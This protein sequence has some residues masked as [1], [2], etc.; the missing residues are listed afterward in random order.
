MRRSRTEV[1]HAQLDEQ[2]FDRDAQLRLR[3][4][5]CSAMEEELFD[6]LNQLRSIDD[7]DVFAIKISQMDV[8]IGQIATILGVLESDG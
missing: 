2:S 5:K 4:L 6:Q 8:F 1:L 3:Q 7:S